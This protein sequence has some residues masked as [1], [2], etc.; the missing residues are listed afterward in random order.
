M[1]RILFYFIFSNI[2][3]ATDLNEID[4]FLFD[5]RILIKEILNDSNLDI[6][7]IRKV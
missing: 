4:V 7:L 3:Q 2:N 5:E 6:F 1:R